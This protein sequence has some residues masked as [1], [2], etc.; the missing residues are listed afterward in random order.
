[1]IDRKLLAKEWLQLNKESQNISCRLQKLDKA[2]RTK[3]DKLA[4]L[5]LDSNTYQ[6]QSTIDGVEMFLVN[7][8][9]FHAV[10][11][12]RYMFELIDTFTHEEYL[13]FENQGYI[14]TLDKE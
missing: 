1:M 6:L 11:K 14:K 10:K 4:E 5:F 12:N 9:Q 8:A 7:N 13:N 3:D 2:T